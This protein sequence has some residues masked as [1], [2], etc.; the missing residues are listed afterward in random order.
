MANIRQRFFVHLRAVRIAGMLNDL[1]G[2]W[3]GRISIGRAGYK[4]ARYDLLEFCFSLEYVLTDPIIATGTDKEIASLLCEYWGT[5]QELWPEAF[6][7]PQ[8]YDIQSILGRSSLHWLLPQVYSLCQARGGWSKGVIKRLLAEM[9]I[10][11]E[12]WHSLG[13]AW[14][15]S[16]SPKCTAGLVEY[17][18]GRLPKA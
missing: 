7:K 4:P 2:P 14:R 3:Q 1:P 16:H 15:L 13:E 9:G 12:F 6:R 17:L 18:R 8:E 5:L 10:K 11:S